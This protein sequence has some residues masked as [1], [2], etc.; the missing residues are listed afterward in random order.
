MCEDEMVWW[1]AIGLGHLTISFIIAFVVAIC[2]G[3]ILHGVRRPP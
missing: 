1:Q 3:W 2:H